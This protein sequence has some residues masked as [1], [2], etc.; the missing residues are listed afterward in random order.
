MFEARRE[1]IR[2]YKRDIFID[3]LVCRVAG[4]KSK[5]INSVKLLI[6]SCQ[7][8]RR[9]RAVRRL[10]CNWYRNFVMGCGISI[11]C[12]YL[13]FDG[14]LSVAVRGSVRE[15]YLVHSIESGS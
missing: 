11:I 5:L 9:L 3:T 10:N 4:I 14:I 1:G 6:V 8:D 12:P 13:Q 2:C 7:R 15:S